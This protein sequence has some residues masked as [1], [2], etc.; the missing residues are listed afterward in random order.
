MA[1]ACLIVSFQI[2]SRVYGES[3]DK[4][5]EMYGQEAYSLSAGL[6]YCKSLIISHISKNQQSNPQELLSFV[7]LPSPS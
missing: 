1:A 3:P 5:T 6:I 2:L 7:G 4:S